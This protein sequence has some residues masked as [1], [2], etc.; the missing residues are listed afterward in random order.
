MCACLNAAL[1]IK[2]V[3]WISNLLL[4]ATGFVLAADLA[5]AGV[6]AE[7]YNKIRILTLGE[8][9]TD[10]TMAIESR[11]KS[12]PKQLEEILLQ[13]GYNVWV[14]NVAKSGSSTYYILRDLASEKISLAI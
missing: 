8:S 1:L 3:R 10:D 2:I 14:Y 13:R 11:S 9:T 4:R 7:D 12:W 6:S 5:K